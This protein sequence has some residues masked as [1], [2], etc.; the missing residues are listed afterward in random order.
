MSDDYKAQRDR[1]IAFSLAGA[2]VLIETDQNLII[3]DVIGAA[4]SVFGTT[5]ADMIGQNLDQYVIKSD[6]SLLTHLLARVQKLGRISSVKLDFNGAKGKAELDIGATLMPSLPGKVFFSLRVIDELFLTSGDRRD[7]TT[8]LLDKDGFQALAQT[9]IDG[10]NAANAHLKLVK[11]DG[12]KGAL[13]GLPS[14]DGQ[15]LMAEIGATLRAHSLNGSA[16]AK[17]DDNAFSFLANQAEEAFIAEQLSREL[18]GALEQVGIDGGGLNP[19]IQ[20]MSLK[21]DNL[22]AEDVTRA[23]AY[24]L[25]DF[26]KTDKSMPSSLKDG[27]D[28]ALK[29]TIHSLDQIRILIDQQKFTLFYQPVV[30]FSSRKARHYEAL[31]RFKDGRNPFETIRLTEQ[32]GLSQELDLAV[33]KLAIET[34]ISYPMLNIA[35]N[36]S[37]GSVPS[38]AF[39]HKLLA[40]IAPHTGLHKRLMFELTETSLIDDMVPAVNFLNHLRKQ[41]FKI[42]L[43]DFGAGASAYSYLRKFDVDYLKIDGQF[44]KEARH[45]K[46]QRALISSISGLCQALE[47]DVIAEMIEDEATALMCVNLGIKY[48][49]GY[50]FGAPVPIH[51]IMKSPDNAPLISRPVVQ[52]FT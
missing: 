46:R 52:N 13:E 18:M 40:L 27:F 24:V 30:P 38:D 31:L 47:T 19:N 6:R 20:S 26:C 25:N 12:L 35:V 29:E 48:G 41:G 16:A 9:L 28:Q 39:R 37:G 34:L 32:F 15:K 1:F 10:P 11:F 43:D 3:T 33:L 45:D 2:D 23:L 17:L 14:E 5:K 44:L 51:E 50:L 22:N 42:A 36:L 4:K 49:Q 21:A 8:G 7:E